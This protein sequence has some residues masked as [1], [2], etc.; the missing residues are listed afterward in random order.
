MGK[1]KMESGFFLTAKSV[2]RKLAVEVARELMEYQK[3]N[4]VSSDWNDYSENELVEGYYTPLV[5]LLY[6]FCKTEKPELSA[7]LIEEL[8]RYVDR[9]LSIQERIDKA[10][11]LL[12]RLISLFNNKFE[13]NI[14]YCNKLKKI[15]SFLINIA[16]RQEKAIVGVAVGDCLMTDIRT[17]LRPRSIENNIPCE[18]DCLYFGAS[19]GGRLPT[20]SVLKLLRERKANYLALSFFSYD[21]LPVYRILKNSYS[22]LSPDE[23][24]GYINNGLQNIK[25][26]IGSIREFSNIP[27]LLH[28]VSG[29]PYSRKEKIFNSVGLGKSLQ[30]VL[31]ILNQKIQDLA[32]EMPKIILI[33]EGEIVKKHGAAACDESIVP[34]AVGKKA[35]FHRKRFGYFLSEQYLNI[36][37]ALSRLEKVKL[38][39]VDFDNTLWH[40]VMGDGEVQ[41]FQDRQELLKKLKNQ[42]IVLVA[43]SKNTA[44]NIR[45]SEMTLKEEDFA[46]L[47]INWNSK[48]QSVSEV[49]KTLNLGTNSFVFLDDNP[50]ERE[51]V[52]KS[53]PEVLCLD[54]N[55]EKTWQWL[56]W[57]FSFPCTAETEESRL[58]TEMYRSQAMRS[59]VIQE[60]SEHDSEEIMKS[61]NL[62]LDFRLA[63]THDVAR[64]YELSQR[65]NQFNTTT[66]RYSKEAIHQLVKQENNKKL[67]V[68]EMSDKFGRLGVVVMAVIEEKY[69]NFLIENF[70]MSC[71]AMGFGLESRFISEVI[72]CFDSDK[73]WVG[74]F[75]ATDRN[76]PSANFFSEQGFINSG[77]GNWVLY[78]CSELVKAP[79]WFSVEK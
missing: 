37:D 41:H 46:L 44:T 13:Q 74:R 67:F 11:N 29:L 4:G 28:N 61:L 21:G 59:E 77:E 40:G 5:I 53:H 64:C 22:N 36:V 52:S 27:I 45:W 47:K 60:V 9:L 49:A 17:C 18:L 34:M 12:N 43:V 51:I 31:S 76:S 35:F 25:S 69:D 14:I 39:L 2:N 58:R 75:L 54:P 70:V 65:T 1:F 73:T 8:F 78:D 10:I 71:R 19:Q 55:Q 48:S 72:N 30:D 68:G 63:N 42:G 79:T 24:V 66:I 57:M 50:V 62:R 33:D 26:F 56:R 32:E 20:E 7:L 16:E 6:E 23:I 38:L 3:A 15:A